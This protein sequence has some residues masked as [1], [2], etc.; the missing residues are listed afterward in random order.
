MGFLGFFGAT[1]LVENTKK[2][3]AITENL[4]ELGEDAEKTINES[5]KNVNINTLEL[6]ENT[7]F[8]QLDGVLS[9]NGM[10]SITLKLVLA[11]AASVVFMVL[12]C[13]LIFK[14]TSGDEEYEKKIA[15]KKQQSDRFI[16]MSSSD[17]LK[18]VIKTLLKGGVVIM[19]C[20]TIWGICALANDESKIKIQAIKERDENK[21]FISLCTKE[22]ARNLLG[23]NCPNVIY[24][25]WPAPLTVVGYRKAS[26]EKI[27]VRVP[28]DKNLSKI[29][30]KTGA[31][32]STSVNI[33]GDK[34]MNNLMDIKKKFANRVTA[35]A[36]DDRKK[37]GKEESTIIDITSPPYK[38]LREGA[39][40]KA[41]LKI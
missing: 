8:K 13:L 40:K 24:E 3:N 34:S 28:D 37:V 7:D 4:K 26:K 5:L 14:K 20:D 21:Q 15:K 6:V 9:P 25:K 22:E 32:Y 38:V 39:I 35:I 29:L 30:A 31:L 10:F 27:A 19:P 1:G 11:L 23:S 2:Y 33:S 18:R 16:D 36:Y 17:G 12:P 41:D